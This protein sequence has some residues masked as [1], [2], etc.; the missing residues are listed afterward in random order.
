ML[1]VTHDISQNHQT[2]SATLSY[3]KNTLLTI[4]NMYIR[5]YITFVFVQI[6]NDNNI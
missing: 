3:K 6:Q 1:S 5:I 4:I 2:I